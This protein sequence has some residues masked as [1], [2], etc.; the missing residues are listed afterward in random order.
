MVIPQEDDSDL[1]FFPDSDFRSL[2][3]HQSNSESRNRTVSNPD[4]V[5]I[6]NGQSKT[7]SKDDKLNQV[8]IGN[9]EE[10]KKNKELNTYNSSVPMA[11]VSIQDML[12]SRVSA[13]VVTNEL[14]FDAQT[15]ANNVSESAYD[16]ADTCSKNDFA[17]SSYV[18]TVGT[19]CDKPT[20]IYLT[21]DSS[22][23]TVNS[24]DSS[25]Y[26]PLTK[27]TQDQFQINDDKLS[28]YMPLNCTSAST[29]PDLNVSSYMPLPAPVGI[30]PT[31]SSVYSA[32]SKSSF[33]R[34]E[35]LFCILT[36]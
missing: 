13:F 36:Y 14:V 28:A 33:E 19:A 16:Y 4:S 35:L 18:A 11:S 15:Y 34:F 17:E 5:L 26:I 1:D 30:R 9:K 20:L 32:V 22:C 27:S 6:N 21:K 12:V 8:E 31:S 10:I 25:A 7:G 29:A 24:V 23:I 3:L 2:T